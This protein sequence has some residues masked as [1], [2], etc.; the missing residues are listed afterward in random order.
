M[1]V[2]Q[3]LPCVSVKVFCF[4]VLALAHAIA[5]QNN[6]ASQPDPAPQKGIADFARENRGE[7]SK[8][9]PEA[10]E[11]AGPQKSLSEFAAERRAKRQAEVKLNEKEVTELL[12]DLTEITDFASSDTGFPEHNRVKHQIVGQDDVKRYWSAALSSSA[13]AERLARSELVLKK[14]GYL[15]HDFTLKKYL[16]DNAA[17]GLGG[18]YD[19]RTKTMNLVNWVGLEHQRPIM[20]HELTHALQDQNFDL[21]Q[22][23]HKVSRRPQGKGMRVD[24]DEAQ[25]ADAR[26]AVIEGQAMVVFFDYLLRP[27][28]HTLAETPSAVDFINARLTSSYDT[29]LVVHNAPLLFKE[30]A[31][32]PYREG[33]LFELELLK[34][35]GINGAFRDLFA[36]P[37]I[38]SHQILE[39]KAYFSGEKIAPV[40]IPDIS[41][42]LGDGYEPY[43][44]GTIGQLDIRVM[45]QQLGTEND[46]FTITPAWKG[47]SYIA[48][49]RSSATKQESL[50]T[51]D[52]ALIYVSRWK[53]AAAA[54]RF[55]EIYKK[56]LA[57]RMGVTDEQQ[58]DGH[59]CVASHCAIWA[60]RVGTSEG[61]AFIEI[62]PNHTVFISQSFPDEIVARLRSRVLLHGAQ[63]R[64]AMPGLDLN[65]RVQSLPGF[66]AFR[67]E[68]ERSLLTNLLR[69]E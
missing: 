42:A 5:V 59:A 15:P 20:A 10:P 60:T 36:H 33:L 22:W 6:P 14:F 39:P 19:P 28:G 63:A 30:S 64:A 41:A 26:R 66:Q 67:T 13:E 25:E 48:A 47:G 44:S 29:S 45:A 62:W 32:F 21:M 24:S 43:D 61:P 11:E 35:E 12:K 23:E 56:S 3:H 18:F 4:L 17:D 58:L 51:A 2:R 27:Y 50:E 53:E 49:R 34:K 40:I 8:A 68:V 9:T 31:M 7:K 1:H 16:V 57:K 38:D 37:P 52:I 69:A 46:M 55:A 65:Q 54:Q